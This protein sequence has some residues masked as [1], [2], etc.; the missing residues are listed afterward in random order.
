[1]R[2]ARARGGG[3]TPRPAAAARELAEIEDTKMRADIYLLTLLQ[4]DVKTA[5]PAMTPAGWAFMGIAWLAIT[6]LTAWTFSK[7]LRK[8]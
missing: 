8:K 3:H 6:F 4:T 5:G 1:M 7:I 2:T